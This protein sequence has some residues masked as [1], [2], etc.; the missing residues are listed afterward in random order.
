[1]KKPFTEQEMDK[2][3]Q[4]K[5]PFWLGPVTQAPNRPIPA[6]SSTDDLLESLLGVGTKVWRQH[7]V[8]TDACPPF[9]GGLSS[10]L[11]GGPGPEN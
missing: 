3:L 2:L 11:G 5:R 6:W 10:A 7:P 1:M 9:H 4:W 8:A